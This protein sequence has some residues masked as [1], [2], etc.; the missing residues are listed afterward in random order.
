MFKWIIKSKFLRPGNLVYVGK[1]TNIF[2]VYSIVKTSLLL[3]SGALFESGMFPTQVGCLGWDNAIGWRTY[4]SGHNT[5]SRSHAS[6]TV[7][8]YRT[9]REILESRLGRSAFVS[10]C[11]RDT[12]VLLNSTDSKS[13][14]ITF[15]LHTKEHS[16]IFSFITHVLFP[17]YSIQYGNDVAPLS[18]IDVDRYM[19][20]RKLI[21]SF[22]ILPL[23]IGRWEI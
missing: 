12:S 16:C 11:V 19:I 7:F 9:V 4:C 10:L 2:P 13:A 17:V 14:A 6:G 21:H 5:S 18:L 22:N 15:L 23:F 3:V 20:I 1:T 8:T